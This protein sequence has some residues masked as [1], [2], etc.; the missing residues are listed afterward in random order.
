MRCGGL[1]ELWQVD[2]LQSL[3]HKVGVWR[4]R[5]ARQRRAH[6]HAVCTCIVYRSAAWRGACMRHENTGPQSPIYS[7]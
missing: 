2:V 1:D 4:Q 3:Q 7:G 6:R 5:L